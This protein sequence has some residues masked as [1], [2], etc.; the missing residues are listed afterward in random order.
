MH[1][2][3]CFSLVSLLWLVF[4]STARAADPQPIEADILLK[5]GTVFDGSGA[6]G[7]IGNVAIKDDKIVGVGTFRV[8]S[9]K[10]EIDCRGLIVAPGFID[11][12]NH[13]D[14]QIVAEKTRANVNFLMQG[15]TTIVTGNCGSG[16][17]SASGSTPATVGAG[18]SASVRP[19]SNSFESA[20]CPK[21]MSSWLQGSPEFWR[22]RNAAS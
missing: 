22:P 21:A 11:L 19:H 16:P 15:C 6:A 2:L 18:A 9:A 20:R 1:R 4:N 14:S 10:L 12:H 17:I 8:T 13:S 7:K 3:I 5:G